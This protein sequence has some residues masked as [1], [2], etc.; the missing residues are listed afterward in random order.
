MPTIQINT[1]ASIDDAKSIDTI[2]SEMDDD[3]HVLDKAI[4][5]TIADG[6]GDPGILTNWSSTVK[7][8]WLQ[9][10]AN[11]VP[12]AFADMKLSAT[13]LRL[14]VDEALRYSNEG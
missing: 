4:K 6:P 7:G 5:D 9:Y 14:A 3:I 1:E 13:N 12:T 11:D 10:V 8:N 2:V